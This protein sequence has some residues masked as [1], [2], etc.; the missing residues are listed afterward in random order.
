MSPPDIQTKSKSGQGK[1]RQS[2]QTVGKKVGTNILGAINVLMC[3]TDAAVSVLFFQLGL[4]D[5]V[6]GQPAS[7]LYAWDQQAIKQTN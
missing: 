4:Q 1:D 3:W 2:L 6:L 7:N 5:L